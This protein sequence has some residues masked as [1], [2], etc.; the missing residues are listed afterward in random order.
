MDE[1]NAKI[2]LGF[3]PYE[4]LEF[5]DDFM[6]GHVMEDP[7]ICRE[8]LECLLQQPVGE[9][10]NIVREKDIRCTSEGKPIRLDIYT[11]DDIRVYDAE[12]QNLNHKSRESL[13]LPKR[14]RFYQSSIDYDHLKKGNNYKSLPESVILFICTFDPFEKGQ[15][16]YTFRERCEEDESIVLNDGTTRIFFNCDYKG[17]DIPED[18]RKLYRYIE[19]GKVG[20]DMTRRLEEAVE[21][22]RKMDWNSDYIREMMVLYDA[23]DEGR[24]EGREEERA[25]TEAERARADS[26]K[27]RAEKAEARA[28]SAENELKMYKERFGELV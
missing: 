24:E 17:S 8:V 15:S 13:A 16:R 23:R 28:N 2:A 19:T 12:M 4:K 22:V 1:V 25:N 14:S 7:K 26:E 20:N 5:R 18:I 27:E 6:F 3:K 9:L 10:H 21:R 11:E